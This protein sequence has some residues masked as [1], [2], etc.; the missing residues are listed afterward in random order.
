MLAD[1][2]NVPV[3]VALTLSWSR[4]SAV[5]YFDRCLCCLSTIPVNGTKYYVYSASELTHLSV[6][7]L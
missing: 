2:D 4:A 6:T 5:A 3:L 7:V 1:V